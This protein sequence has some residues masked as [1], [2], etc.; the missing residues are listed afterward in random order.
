MDLVEHI[1]VDVLHEDALASV[2]EVVDTETGGTTA[3]MFE[4]LVAHPSDERFVMPIRVT[5]FDVDAARDQALDN[6]FHP[7]FVRSAILVQEPAVVAPVERITWDHKRALSVAEDALT[8]NIKWLAAQEAFRVH[9]IPLDDP[10]SWID[11]EQVKIA[12]AAQRV[13]IEA[14]RRYEDVKRSL[15]R[16]LDGLTASLHGAFPETC[17]VAPVAHDYT[18]VT[19]I[20]PKGHKL[21]LL[22]GAVVIKTEDVPDG[23]FAS[24]FRLV[25]RAVAELKRSSLLS[26]NERQL[27]DAAFVEVRAKVAID[28]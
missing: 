3:V 12:R 14:Q 20:A 22:P 26:V 8:Q 17:P 25:D 18:G 6:E 28:A 21:P 23:V 1:L 16:A 13:E 5:A 11:A 24:G 4:W 15:E 2:G 9:E 27:L 10:Q 7:Q 19:V